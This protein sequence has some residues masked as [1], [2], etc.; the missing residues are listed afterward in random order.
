MIKIYCLIMLII[1]FNEI[2]VGSNLISKLPTKIDGWQSFQEDKIYNRKSIYNYL[3]GGAELYLAYDMERLFSRRYKSNQRGDIVVDIFEMKTS[4]NAFGIFSHDYEGN[5]LKI[6]DGS[7]YEM[8]LLIFW[9][10]RYYVSVLAENESEEAKKAVFKIA[11][12]ISKSISESGTVPDVINR[13]KRKGFNLISRHYFQSHLCLNFYYYLSDVNVL[14]LSES[15][16][17]VIGRYQI[18]DK[19][20]YAVMIQYL[21]EKEAKDALLSFQAK[22][23]KTKGIQPVAVL[24]DGKWY[25]YHQAGNNVLLILD[26][27][28][29]EIALKL[30]GILKQ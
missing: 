21:T 7:V 6:G 10:G 24:K 20:F 14:N 13:L 3:D 5:K 18:G 16:D 12:L 1:L 26:S 30:I 25:A 11:H 15:T 22:F 29:K 9:K 19:I 27:P 17:G 4:K 28:S 23:L 8:G 2:A